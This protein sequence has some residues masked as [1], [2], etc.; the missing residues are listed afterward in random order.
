[1]ILW[2]CRWSGAVLF[3]WVS[4]CRGSRIRLHGHC[5]CNGCFKLGSKSDCD[6]C[7]TFFDPEDGGDMLLRNVGCYSTDYMASYPSRWHSC[8]I[9]I[10]YKSKPFVEIIAFWGVAP[11]S[12]VDRYKCFGGAYLVL[13]SAGSCNML[14][15]ACQIAHHGVTEHGD[16]RIHCCK[17]LVCC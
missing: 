16:L 14:P 15:P 9:D 1:M 7:W 11:W 13:Y 6:V 2:C 4:D 12:S 10:V 8:M 17:I 5:N 3:R